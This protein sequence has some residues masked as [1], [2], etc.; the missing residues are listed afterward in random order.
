[1]A[2]FDF[3]LDKQMKIPRKISRLFIT[4]RNMEQQNK[5]K[6]KL[7]FLFTYMNSLMCILTNV[8]VRVKM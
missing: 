5:E 4:Y 7:Y 2:L 8:N 6:G 1:M 3:L